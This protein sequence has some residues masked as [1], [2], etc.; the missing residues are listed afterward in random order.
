MNKFKAIVTSKHESEDKTMAIIDICCVIGDEGKF[1]IA[2]IP[3]LCPPSFAADVLRDL[4]DRIESHE[5]VKE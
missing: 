2:S 4:A 5:K 1:E 3:Y